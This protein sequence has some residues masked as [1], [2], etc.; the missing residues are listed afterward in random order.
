MVLFCLDLSAG[1]RYGCFVAGIE[2]GYGPTF[3]V[4]NRSLLY[5][6]ATWGRCLLPRIGLD[7]Q[8]QV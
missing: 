7:L 6:N 8:C 1:S 5:L 2:S 3:G 4:G